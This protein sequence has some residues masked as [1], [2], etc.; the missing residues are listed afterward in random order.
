MP[1]LIIFGAHNLQTFKL[2]T[3]INKLLLMQFFLFHIRPNLHRR[4]W[5]KLRVGVTS[6]CSE[7]SQLHQQPADAVVCPTFIRKL[8]YKLPSDVSF[9]FIQTFDQNFV[10]FTE[11]RHVDRQCEA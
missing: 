8:C 9:T 7:L 4:K 2:N 1:K 3:L 10:F 5:R 11:W 6:H